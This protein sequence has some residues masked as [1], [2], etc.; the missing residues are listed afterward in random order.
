MEL[1]LLLKKEQRLGGLRI[2]Y[3]LCTRFAEKCR[4]FK[5]ILRPVAIKAA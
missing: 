4:I 2:F 5:I 1:L 3:Y